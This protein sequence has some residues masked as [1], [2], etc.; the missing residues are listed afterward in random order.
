[1]CALDVPFAIGFPRTVVQ[2]EELQ[3]IHPITVVINVNVPDQ[4]ILERLKNRWV[5][6]PSGRIYNLGFNDPKIPVRN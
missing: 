6:L 2:A 1:M 4:I 3:K 5:H